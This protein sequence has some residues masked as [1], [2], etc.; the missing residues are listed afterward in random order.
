MAIPCNKS[1]FLTIT[2]L[3]NLLRQAGWLEDMIAKWSAIIIYESAGCPLASNKVG[4]Y[5]IGLLQMNM[6]AH[7]TKYGTENQLLNPLFNLQQA[8]K[9]WKIQGD[10]AWINS[11]KK[12]R[13]NLNGIAEK[14]RQIYNNGT[15]TVID[16]D[17]VNTITTSNQNIT[18]ENIPLTAGQGSGFSND[19]IAVAV[20][21]LL[22]LLL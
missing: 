12:Y 15:Q 13:N 19:E 8:Y 20:G 17:T 4:E 22:L 18:G 6:K 10:R 21:L 5:S 2:Q 14:A 16:T 11:V 1:Q 3:Q 7:G 9:L